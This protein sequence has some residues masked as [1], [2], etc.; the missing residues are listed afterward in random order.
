MIITAD[1][2]MRLSPK[3]KFP[4]Q[5]AAALDAALLGS[6]ITKQ[7]RLA[8]FL[9]QCF[10]ETAGFTTLTENL[11]YTSPGRL[12][13]T[14][15][16]VK[17]VEDAKSL[18][19]EGPQAIANRIYANRLGNGPGSSG[20][21]WRYR[22]SGYKQLTGRSNFREMGRILNLP[23]EAHPEMARENPTAAKVAVAFWDWRHLSI[24]ADEMDI[25]AIT[26]IVNG[27][28]KLGLAARIAATHKAL[29]VFN[30]A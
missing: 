28:S 14:F 6:T 30:H 8:C 20:D 19:A 29:K 25:E 15:L 3:A 23:L 7:N 22:G 24:L 1:S 4:E 11:N 5:Q 12:D 27:P 26:A 13:D 16:A 10:V 9:G 17:S 18:I 21:G 2:L